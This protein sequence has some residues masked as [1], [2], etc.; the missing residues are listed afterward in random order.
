MFSQIPPYRASQTKLKNKKWWIKARGIREIYEM[1]QEQYIE[2]IIKERNHKNLYVR[3]EAQI[4]MVV[5]LGWESL[6]FLPYLEWEMTLWQQIKVIEKLYDLYPIPNLKYLKKAFQTD[7]PYARELLMRI[8]K[9]FDIR[10]E[11]DYIIQFLDNPS[12]DTRETALYCISTF[13]LNEEKMKEVQEKF[14]NIPNTE[15]KRQ[16]LKYIDKV[17]EYRDLEFFKKLL[18]SENEVIKLTSA[19]ILWENGNEEDVQK[20]YYQQYENKVVNA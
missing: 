16:L 14:L 19:E 17:S 20:Y 10:E 15:Q 3:R 12:F 1:H 18:Y 13:N 7:K 9:K 8:I 5:F 2:D 6:R 4:A 11:V